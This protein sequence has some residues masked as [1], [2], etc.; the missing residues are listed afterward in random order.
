MAP[1][2]PSPERAVDPP[3]GSRAAV[4]MSIVSASQ[5]F[6][7]GLAALLEE[8]LDI[9]LLGSYAADDLPP[10]GAPGADD[11]IV[12]LDGAIGLGAIRRWTR[13][14]RSLSP[15]ARVIS[16]EL[17]DDTDLIVACIEAGVAAYTVRGASAAEVAQAICDVRDNL[18]HSA[19]HVTA[20]LFARLA[21]MADQ[22]SQP[23]AA[24]TPLLTPRE[25]E[26]LRH[27]SE[28]C[29]NKEIARRMVIE[30]RTVKH[31]VHSIL[32]KLQS[33]HRWDA[34]RLARE[35]GWLESD[36]H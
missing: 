14:W 13:H 29:T 33:R 25:L 20:G 28:D 23:L 21:A 27:L 10:E 18:A 16:V 1:V 30:V 4:R 26:V 11:H 36:E 12:V 19:P 17:L 31:H 22:S 8:H 3:S 34:V 32:R 5:L 2:D 24:A 9:A 7:Q 6:R 15:P 35:R